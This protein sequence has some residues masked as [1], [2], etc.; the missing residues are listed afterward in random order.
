ME[1]F[2]KDSKEFSYVGGE[3][4]WAEVI[5]NV[6]WGEDMIVLH[7][8]VDFNTNSTLI[9][10]PGEQAIFEKNGQIQQ[11]FTEGRYQLS[12]ENYPFISRLRNVFTGGVSTFNCRVFFIRT[13]TSMEMKWGIG[14]I[15]VRDKKLRVASKVFARGAYR[16]QVGDGGQFL[17]KLIGNNITSYGPEQ[18]ESYFRHEFREIIKTELAAA[19]SDLEGEILG[20]QARQKELSDKISPAIAEVM[21][22]YGIKLNKFSISAIEVDLD[23]EIRRNY[24]EKVGN[25]SADAE[26][27]N[28]LGDKWAA[29]QQVDIMMAIATNEETG[30]VGAGIGL[31]LAALGSFH[32]MGQ[33]VIGQPLSQPMP[34]PL[35]MASFYLYVDSQQVGPVPMQQLPLYVQAGKLTPD[36]LVWKEGMPQWAAAETV[37]ELQQLFG[38]QTPPPIPSTTTI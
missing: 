26:V 20:I 12:T 21:E 4:H 2:K 15:Q 8:D 14:K 35:P 32:Q 23:D 29:Q 27:M 9:V 28:I 31:G 33:Q 13:V 19:L 30:T 24:E 18:I 11:T 17:F 3:K 38:R 25:A 22:D 36:T 6:G 37:P 5:E 10:H 1:L 16:V 7:P 34:P